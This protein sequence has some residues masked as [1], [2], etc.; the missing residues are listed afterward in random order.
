MSV[1]SDLTYL[2]TL[3]ATESI[4]T[5]LFEDT[6]D[7]FEIVECP[8]RDVTSTATKSFTVPITFGSN[9]VDLTIRKDLSDNEW[10]ITEKGTVNGENF[11]SIGK[12]TLGSFIHEHKDFTYILVSP[13]EYN[14]DEEKLCLQCIANSSI[15][16]KY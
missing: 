15:L 13:Y 6:K 2:T 14:P 16:I 9:T 1:E 4:L 10:W 7:D 5:A 11:N 8:F 3:G 12:Y